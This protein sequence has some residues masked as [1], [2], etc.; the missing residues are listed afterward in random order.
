[1]RW[2]P[3]TLKTTDAQFWAAESPLSPGCVLDIMT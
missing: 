3:R 1:M 2:Y